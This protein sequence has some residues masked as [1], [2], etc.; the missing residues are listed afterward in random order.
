MQSS[1]DVEV[2][3]SFLSSAKYLWLNFHTVHH[4]FPHT[5]MSKHPG[6]QRVLLD[7]LKEF[8]AVK[9]D[10]RDFWPMY[11]EMLTSFSTASHL[12]EEI[13]IYPGNRCSG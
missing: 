5:D 1:S 9:Y 6:L 11:K 3:L 8:P 10:V 2:G 4:L 12:G 13:N 7:T